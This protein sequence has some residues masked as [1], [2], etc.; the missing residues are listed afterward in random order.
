[1]AIILGGCVLAYFLTAERPEH[2]RVGT[3]PGALTNLLLLAL[4]IRLGVQ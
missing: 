3:L 2:E 1:M 4:T